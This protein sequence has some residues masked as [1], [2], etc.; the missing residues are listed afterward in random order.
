MRI[1]PVYN[2][3]LLETKNGRNTKDQTVGCMVLLRGLEKS[4]DP[5]F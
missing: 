4:V 2:E 1:E 3:Q 5:H